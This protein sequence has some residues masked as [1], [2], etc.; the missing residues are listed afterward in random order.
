MKH[1]TNDFVVLQHD[2][3]VEFILK[4][5]IM[6]NAISIDKSLLKHDKYKISQIYH[7]LLSKSGTDPIILCVRHWDHGFR[8]L[9]GW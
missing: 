8:G 5:N 3:I 1:S 2:N 4:S 7:K 6:S 9:D